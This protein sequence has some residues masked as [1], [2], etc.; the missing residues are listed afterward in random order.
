MRWLLDVNVLVALAFPIHAQHKAAHEW[1]AREPDRLWATCPLTQAGFIRIGARLL[2]TEGGRSFRDAIRQTIA[3]LEEDC[4]SA[5]HE[6]WL[7]DIDLL[8][9]PD[10]LRTRLLGPNQ[11]AD[12]QLAL[13]A[14][15]RKGRLATFDAG[16]R[17]LVSGT[18]YEFSVQ[19]L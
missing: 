6:Y 15:R 18:R 10:S 8:A 9:L 11:V 13:V 14:H 2:T 16:I 7:A 1:F 5:Q 19:V 12:L 17:E 4:R 3:S